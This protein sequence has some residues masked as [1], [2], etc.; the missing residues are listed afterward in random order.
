MVRLI[1]TLLLLA[2]GSA[3]LA[4]DHWINDKRLI[5]PVSGQWCCNKYDCAALPENG[6]AEVHGGY[7]VAETGEVIPYKRIIWRSEDGSWWR[8]RN[9]QTNATRCLIGPPPAN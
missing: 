7:S 9:L 6:V 4:H 1:A 5:D 3:A 8:C 2:G